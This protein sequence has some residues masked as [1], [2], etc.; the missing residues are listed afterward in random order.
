MTK[1]SIIVPIYKVEPYLRRCV[2][3]ILAQTFTDFELILV[4]DGSPDNC[5]AICDEYAAKDSRI[6]VIHKENGGLSD[7][8][9]AGLDIATGEFIGFVKVDE[10]GVSLG[11]C[12]SLSHE[13]ILHRKDFIDNFYPDTRWLIFPS[14]WNK[15]FRRELFQHLRF[16][17]GKIYEDSLLQLSLYE[18]CNTIVVDNQ[19]HY[20]YFCARPDSIMNV[21]YSKK[22]LALIDVALSQYEF[23]VNKKLPNQQTFALDQY[24]TSYCKLFFATYRSKGI[25]QQDFRPYRKQFRSFRRR[26]LANPQICRMKKIMVLTTC[27]SKKLAFLLCK[28]YFPECVPEY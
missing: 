3:S 27:M 17:V 15:V 1:L 24:I 23:F 12:P 10:T 14:V 2:D 8:R 20:F 5:G 16:P 28:K 26:I 13:H 6:I 19:H 9:N 11:L 7:A 4:D 18:L 25:S 22:N 21:R